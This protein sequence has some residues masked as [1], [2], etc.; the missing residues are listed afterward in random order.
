MKNLVRC[1][2]V[3]VSLLSLQTR[4]LFA[5]RDRIT[6]TIDRSRMAVLSGNVH[7][8]AQA[9]Y[10]QGPA[11]PSF[12]I[13]Y[14]TLRLKHSPEQQAAL[15][16]LLAEQQD[17]PSPNFHKWVTPEQY[18]DRFSVSSG[19]TAKTVSWLW[20]EGFTV[21]EVARG[22]HWIAFSGTAGQAASAFRTE[23]HRYKVEGETYFANATEPSIPAALADVVDGFDGLNDFPLRSMIGTKGLAADPAFN[24]GGQHYL[25]P[26][27]LAM[28]YD[29]N[30][31][32]NGGVNGSGQKIVIVGQGDINVA[33]IQAFRTRFHLPPLDLQTVL[34]GSDPGNGGIEPF[35]DIEWAGAIAPNASII[36]VY[37]KNANTAAQF[38]VD[39]NLAPVISESYGACEPEYG[40]SLRSIAQQ[41]NAQGITW[42]AASGDSGAAGCERQGDH[43]QATRGMAVS[44]P[45]SL[46]EVTAVGGSQ[47]N[48]GSGN[49][50]STSNGT[51][52]GSALSYIPETAWNENDNSGLYASGGGASIF[53]RK[54]SWQTG[55]GVPNDN[56]R[57]V[58]DISLSSA[59]HD[60]Y[61]VTAGGVNYIVFGT[62]AATLFCGNRCDAQPVRR[63]QWFS[64]PARSGQYQPGALSSG[65][66]RH[67][68]LSRHYFRRQ[69]CRM[70]AEQ[71][72]LSL[73]LFRL[74]CGSRL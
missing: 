17:R 12:S 70:R 40:P 63:V 5:Q 20:S 49:F 33:D 6:S 34:V 73:W 38:A 39:H 43:P 29:I 42:L 66:E 2:G 45:A 4:P 32:Y 25:A 35:L 61:W 58:P 56:A 72:R 47:F 27:D 59:S 13:E 1:L 9:Q 31:L 57:D 8:K 55:P 64:D 48:E 21:N 11:D 69:H 36:Y 10:D 53:F 19:D 14:V 50:W 51:N 62:S 60:G 71:S 24:V 65:S 26:D 23:I 46:P 41:A 54:P 68:R 28:I 67:R 7:A 44:F 30:P 74:C 15:D 18:A 3:V 22:R 52:S 16:R 37:G